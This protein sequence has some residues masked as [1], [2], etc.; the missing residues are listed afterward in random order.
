[1]RCRA[2]RITTD[3]NPAV[4]RA[5]PIKLLVVAVFV[6]GNG[7]GCNGHG[8][9]A[10]E[11]RPKE[12]RTAIPAPRRAG[13]DWPR[14]LGP[15]GTGVSSET[16]LAESWPADGPPIVW[17]KSIGVGYSAPSVR[18]NRLVFHHRQGREEIVE[19][20]QAD[21]GE[22]VWKYG[23]STS[24]RD[25][26][27]Y[28]DGPRCTPLLT[29]DRCYTFGAEGKLLCLNLET[30]NEIWL[31]DTQKDF[32]VPQAFFGVGCTPILEGN[33]LITLVGG[34]PNSGVVAFDAAT[35]KTVWESVGR[36]TWH[37]A[38][39]GLSNSPKYE[40]TGDE[41][42]VSYSS[43]F[44]ATIHGRRHILCLMRQGLVSV[45][46]N[47]GAVNFKYWFMSRDY[48]SVNAARPVVIGDKIFL[49]AAYNVG[50]ALLEVNPDGKSIRE[51][52]RNTRNMLNHWSTATVVGD[53]IY[54]FSG[55]HENEAELRCLEIAT[56]KI[57][58]KTSGFDGQIRDLE[59]D[60]KTGAILD[61]KSGQ[62]IPFPFFG[63]GSMT[64]A[65]GKFLVL[66]ER[67]T[68]ALAKV[69]SEKFEEISRTS[70][71][72]ISYPVW[73]AP[74]LSHGFLYL[75]DEDTLLCLDLI[76][77]NDDKKSSKGTAR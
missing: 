12:V 9:A 62:T 77:A 76:P 11:E 34:Q 66:G 33:L 25:P 64:L 31:R 44:A 48:E 43:P 16:G 70:Y 1:M 30:G 21:T 36:D 47:D 56:G 5:L 59:Q 22:P 38:E 23:Y 35:G 72:E 32:K 60:P 52:W 57:V 61:K 46:P 49:S 7:F 37:G 40:W 13:E 15:L 65:D 28:N 18:G 58:W 6:V 10:E 71:K 54:G 68:L 41:M 50:S 20:V 53:N 75:R 24:Y 4:G 27:G 63:R 39:T 42:V 2:I 26:Y 45:D 17:S 51:V 19:C 29:K 73:P 14:F 3:G 74:V 69:N 67:G 8:T 55:R